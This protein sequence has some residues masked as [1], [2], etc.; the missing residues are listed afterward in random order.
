MKV[1]ASVNV[2]QLLCEHRSN[3][4][5]LDVVQPQLSWILTSAQRGEKQTAYQILVASSLDRLKVDAGDL[6]DSGKVLSDETA[7]ITYQG[8]PLTSH[9]TCYWKI[10]AWDRDGKPSAWSHPA[11]WSMGLLS[12]ADWTAEWISDPIL[13][14]PSNRPMT[15]VHCY[16]S[17]LASHPDTGKWIVL[18]LGSSKPMDAV[19]V[20]PA[21]PRGQSWDFRT[22]MFP[23]RFKL[24]VADNRDFR[25][26]QTVV[27]QTGVDFPNPRG[28]SCRFAF[29]AVRAR[30]VRLGVTRLSRWDGQVYGLA[31]GGISVFDGSTSIAVGADVDCSDSVE[32]E[33]WSKKFLVDGQAAVTLV[34]SSALDAGMPDT[35][36]K[37]TVS[38]VPMLRR[39][40]NLAGQVRR[41]TLSVTARGFYEVH[42]NGHRVGDELLAPGYTDYNVRL[43]YQTYDVTDL[44]HRGTNAIGAL[45]GY[46][47]YA[48]HMNLFENRCIYGCF[49]QFLAQL[50]VELKDGTQLTLGTDGLWRSTLDGPV[51][52]SDLLDGEGYDCRREMP[53]WD[54]PGFDDHA[55][56]PV[57]SQPRD[58]V[59]LV[60]QRSQP[61][62]V[63]REFQPVAVKAVRPG[64]YVFDLGQ[65]ITGWCR[66]QVAGPD[67]THVRLR[68]SEMVSSDGNIDVESLMGTLAGEDYI[69]AGKGQH[70][71]EP[72]FT[73]HGFRY[74]ELSGL[75]G[76]LKP[77]TLV[78]VNVRTD[79][80]LK[81]Q[82][83]C[84]NDLYDHIQKAATWTE[85]NLLF[86]VPAGCAARSERVA[87]MGDVRPC[88]QSLLFNFDAAPLLTKCAGDIRDDQTPDGCFTDIAPHAHLRGTRVC[89][90]TPG[91]ADAGVSLPWQAYV[92][93]GDKRL[94]TEHFAAAKH[95]VDAVHAG[96]P[97]LLWRNNRGQD[98]GDWLSAGKETPKELGATAFFAHSADLLSRMAQVLGDQADAE[99][100]QT[101]FQGIR[102]AFVKNYVGSNGIISD[103]PPGLPA[104]RDVTGLVRSQMINGN[105]AFTVN[106]DVLGGDPAPNQIK[107]LHLLVRR[108]NVS[109]A[110][111]F[112]E[113]DQV[114]MGV[115]AGQ[116]LEI[117]SARYG[118]ADND[119]GDTQ[120]SYALA[121]QFGLLDE[122]LRSQAV[123]RL[124]T[125]VVQNKFHPTTGFW[126]S[127]ELL[128][129]LSDSGF[130]ATAAEMVAQRD[131]PSWGYMANY[132]TTMWESFDADTRKIS[133]DHW[134]HSAVSEWL[135][136]NVAGLNPDEQQPGYQSFTIHPRPTREVTWCQAGYDSIRGSIL[137]DWHLVGGV[138]T[139]T[140]TV[141]AN[142]TATVFVPASGPGEVTESGKP[143]TQSQGVSLL[144]TEPGWVVFHVESGSYQFKSKLNSPLASFRPETN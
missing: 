48:G 3:P 69:L 71:L 120:G 111:T 53:G 115:Q 127:S 78:A 68:T 93:T 122:P 72:H 51:R 106:N 118:C 22:A 30:Y 1:A 116:P 46:G 126:S 131:E 89:V 43:Q 11:S 108:G 37:F 40:F 38:R 55:W 135:W 123:Q 76:K 103:V 77:D 132:N 57:W 36:K 60:W 88:V 13:A 133:L 92:N 49:P 119:L 26:A 16:R 52:W 29:T 143:A 25:D 128:L 112:L 59:P 104:M 56:Q 44:L 17:E 23:L 66:L 39:E 32:S 34:D 136:R 102:R 101:L 64:V 83:E 2:G 42:L 24:E 6:W 10:R 129:A 94:L 19:D 107:S 100:Y 84:S 109:D 21:R 90:G 141:P 28:D 125:L 5:G 50:N 85:A 15:P 31:L 65:E 9:Q 81:G 74:V 35:V 14:D 144:R 97:D 79:A 124:N 70:T 18:D 130:N 91:W 82:F 142:A 95:W 67:G 105:L 27:D 8:K 99:H 4:I 96:N 140:L 137:C 75:P 58:N 134:P 12:P 20:I 80:A 41:A 138:F 61:V 45:L 33:L 87:W 62:R 117:I 121:L 114:A 7:Q 63:I 110:R 139:L 113:G 86:D 47:W 98:W 54:K 73:Y